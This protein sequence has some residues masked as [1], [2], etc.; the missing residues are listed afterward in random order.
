MPRVSD[1]EI[2]EIYKRIHEIQGVFMGCD[3]PK[4]ARNWHDQFHPAGREMFIRRVHELATEAMEIFDEILK[5][6]STNA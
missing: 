1:R 2:D 5:R 6:E 3:N 4:A